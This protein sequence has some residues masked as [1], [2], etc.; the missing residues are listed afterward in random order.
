MLNW[1]CYQLQFDSFS[2]SAQS[3]Q[4]LIKHLVYKSLSFRVKKQFEEVEKFPHFIGQP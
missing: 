3:L 1:N 4:L 2:N